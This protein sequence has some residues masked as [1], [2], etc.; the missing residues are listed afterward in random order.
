[1][2][3]ILASV[4]TPIFQI[5]VPIFE[6]AGATNA[7]EVNSGCGEFTQSGVQDFELCKAGRINEP[8]FDEFQNF[9]DIPIQTCYD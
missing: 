5:T 6:K 9:L 2:H 7:A 3:L 4:R 1:L 8:P